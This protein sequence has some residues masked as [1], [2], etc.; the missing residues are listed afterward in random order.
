MT[1]NKVAVVLGVGA[2]QGLGAAVAI[3]FAREG[4]T[5]VVA[6]RTEASLK[7]VVEEIQRQGFKAQGVATDS[8][9]EEQITKLLAGAEQIGPVEVAVFN[10]GGNNPR[11]SLDTTGAFFEDMWR[12]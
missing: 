12:V 4:Y 2:L 5:A 11:G 10:A 8:T 9:S 1:A 6:G 3:R 7:A